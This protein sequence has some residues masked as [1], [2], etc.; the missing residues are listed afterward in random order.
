MTLYV[1]NVRLDANGQSIEDFKAVTEREVEY[2]KQ[3][4][5]MNK[6]GHMQVTPR[7]GVSVD[8]VVPQTDSE[9]NWEA[10]A[11]GR[12]S[13]EYLNGKR[14]TY[15]G[16]YVL[17]IGEAKADGENEIVKVIELGAE[18]RIDE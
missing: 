3:V 15:T 14:R 16:V 9:F 5:L 4:N 2:Y 18:G 13:I 1:G 8:Y 17:K 10:M 7:Y 6:T 12:L 11:D